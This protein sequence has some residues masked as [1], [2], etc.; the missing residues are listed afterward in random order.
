MN[1][2]RAKELIEII[3]D[4]M[5]RRENMNVAPVIEMLIDCGFTRNE[6]I[7]DFYFISDDVDK[8]INNRG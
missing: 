2:E 3:I 5:I 8:I 4:T 6:L 1:G 7:D